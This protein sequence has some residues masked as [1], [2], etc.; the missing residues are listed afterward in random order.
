[1]S[2]PYTRTSR[3]VA[4]A[5]VALLP[6]ATRAVTAQAAPAG[7]APTD[8]AFTIIEIKPADGALT[9]GLAAAVKAAAAR[10]Q[11]PVVEFSASWCGPC[12]ELAASL[13]DPRMID[14]FRGIYLVRLDLDAWKGHLAGTKIPEVTAI[15]AFFALGTD[16]TATGATIDGGAWG[17]NIPANMAPPLKAFFTSAIQ[18]FGG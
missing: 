15:P 11:T 1:M 14:A 16:G 3:F 2:R 17:D 9:P 12:K 13:G 10:H 18:H 7:V 4:G 5:I 6:L 8:S